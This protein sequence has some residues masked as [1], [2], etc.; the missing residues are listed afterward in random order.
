M[1]NVHVNSRMWLVA[2]ILHSAALDCP[3]AGRAQAPASMRV[4]T[5]S[6]DYNSNRHLLTLIVRTPAHSVTHPRLRSTGGL[7]L[8]EGPLQVRLRQQKPSARG[9]DSA[10]G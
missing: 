1:V 8:P 10:Q 4:F 2:T 7:E 6:P 3:E 5:T 9:S